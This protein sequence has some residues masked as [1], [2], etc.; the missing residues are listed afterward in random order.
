MN[1]LQQII[2]KNTITND[3]VIE[4]PRFVNKIR[5]RNK[6][7]KEFKTEV[8]HKQIAP[9]ETIKQMQEMLKNAVK[10]GTGSSLY[11]PYFSIAGK[12]GTAQAEYWM[13]DWASNRRYISSFAGYFPAENPK[14]S[15]EH[16]SE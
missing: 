8:V 7:I 5:S 6:Q 16:T 14:R 9:E 15:E 3:R 11:S 4:K 10:R 12:T 2:V 1:N 13:D